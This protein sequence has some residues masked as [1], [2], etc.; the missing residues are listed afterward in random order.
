MVH[1]APG[2]WPPSWS[3]NEVKV[4]IDR[5]SYPYSSSVET[6]GPGER[7]KQRP[8]SWL[9]LSSPGR[10]R[11]CLLCI[12]G[13]LFRVAFVCLPQEASHSTSLLGCT[14]PPSEPMSRTRK[15]SLWGPLLEGV[16]LSQ[17]FL[18]L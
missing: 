7:K 15:C 4:L 16:V 13:M 5:K 14:G 3:Q 17:S 9:A 8:R 1:V 2:S 10:L 6:I 11:L 18:R 12:P